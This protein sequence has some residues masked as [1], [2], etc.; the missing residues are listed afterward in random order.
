MKGN[1]WVYMRETRGK[2][3]GRHKKEPRKGKKARRGRREANARH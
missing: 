2:L 3:R 1:N